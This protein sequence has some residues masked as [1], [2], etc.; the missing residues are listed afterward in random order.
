M[1]KTDDTTQ[2]R[3]PAEWERQQ[4]ILMAMPHDGTDW[5]DMLPEVQ[6]C[7]RNIIAGITGGGERVLLVSPVEC[8]IDDKSVTE[9]KVETDDTW[10]RDYGPIRVVDGGYSRLLDFTFNAWGMKFAACHDNMV[11]RRLA[12]AGALPYPLE[13]ALD[14]VLEGGSIESDGRG[15]LMT[16]SRCLLSPNRNDTL[17]REEIEQ[18]LKS[19]LGVKQVLWLDYGDIAGDDTDGHIDTLARFAPGGIILYSP[20][21]SQHETM[22]ML[23]QLRTF[24]DTEGVPYRLIALPE[25]PHLHD[26]DGHL[27][28]ATYANFLVTNNRVLVPAY[29]N[30]P[31]DRTALSTIQACFADREVIGID[32]RA[33]IKQHGSLHCAT[34]NI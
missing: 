25:A 14:V 19:R 3:L 28:P 9:V 30:E 8:G 2:R 33:L 16:T 1:N 24:T 12:D 32:C 26:D 29:G 23:A 18:V 27:M 34:M 31:T 6:E 17:K 4:L 13:S 22:Q 21:T 11:N 10:T 5:S 20:S 7:Y 15:T